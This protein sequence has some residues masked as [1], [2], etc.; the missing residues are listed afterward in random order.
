MALV[1]DPEEISALAQSLWS[2][3]IASRKVQLITGTIGLNH[4]LMRL[5][6][7]LFAGSFLI[8]PHMPELPDFRNYLLTTFK[9]HSFLYSMPNM[10]CFYCW[11]VLTF[12]F[13]G[14][15]NGCK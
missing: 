6:R 8:E 7:N 11:Y 15:T 2:Y 5:W 3:R 13:L 1:L 14:G 4:N 9:V 10:W 12:F